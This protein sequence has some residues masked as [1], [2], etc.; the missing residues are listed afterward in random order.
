MFEEP[1]LTA[2]DLYNFARSA[3]QRLKIQQ[4][5]SFPGK[6]EVA[7]RFKLLWLPG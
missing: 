4:A 6:I 3:K 1:H 5:H 2:G 7:K